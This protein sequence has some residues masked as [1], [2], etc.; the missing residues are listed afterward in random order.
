MDILTEKSYFE[1]NN[2]TADN[3]GYW[4]WRITI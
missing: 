4:Q 1:D 3:I 2:Q